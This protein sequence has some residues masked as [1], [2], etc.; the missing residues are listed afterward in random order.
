MKAF[1][2]ARIFATM[3]LEQLATCWGLFEPQ[4]FWDIV[5]LARARYE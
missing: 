2:Y 3:T 4:E 5:A 1:D